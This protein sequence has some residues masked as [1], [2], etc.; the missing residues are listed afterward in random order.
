MISRDEQAACERGLAV[1]VIGVLFASLLR[2]PWEGNGYT[3]HELK[4]KQNPNGI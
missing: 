3:E 1:A 4:E 2:E